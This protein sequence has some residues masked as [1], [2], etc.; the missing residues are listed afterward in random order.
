MVIDKNNRKKK[1]IN[2]FVLALNGQEKYAEAEKVLST[3][4]NPNDPSILINRIVAALHENKS[5]NELIATLKK[6]APDHEW[7][8]ETAKLAN[9][10]DE[11]MV[12]VKN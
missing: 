11:A 8:K 2:F 9:V 4:Q 12:K 7:F 10:F 5:P 3:C 1:A 6:V